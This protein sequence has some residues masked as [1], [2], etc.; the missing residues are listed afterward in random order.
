MPSSCGEVATRTLVAAPCSSV[1]KRVCLSDAESTSAR[2]VLRVQVPRQVGGHDRARVDGVGGD[3]VGGPAARRLDGEQDVGG[4]GL[5]VGQ[6]TGRTAREVKFRSSKITGERRCPTELSDTI[7]ASPAVGERVV[8]AE[9]ERE[10]AEVVGREL[11]LPALRRQLELGQRHHAGVVDQDVQRPAP[12][13]DEG[14]DGRLVGEVEPAD[15][16]GGVAGGGGD[17]GG[18]PLAGVGV[19][20]GERDFGA[21]AGQRAG[22]LDPDARRAAGDDRA[23]AREVDAGDHLGGGRVEAE[24]GL[25][26]SGGNSVFHTRN[27]GHGTGLRAQTTALPCCPVAPITAIIF[28]LLDNI[29]LNGVND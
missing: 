28:L 13:R 5:P 11:H 6:R 12:V 26:E 19:A 3:A 17:V 7:R 9:C 20:H 18:G 22:G 29:V 10:V 1:L 8:Q 16:D 24:A 14:G 2:Q 23:L 15:V 4:L 25:D 27:L 21:R